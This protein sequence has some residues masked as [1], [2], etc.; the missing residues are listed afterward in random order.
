MKE[1]ANF[2]FGK[3]QKL[4]SRKTLEE[5]FKSESVYFSY[6]LKCI[7]LAKEVD[8]YTLPKVATIAPKRNFK[9]AVDRN[10]IKR[11]IRESYR[12]NSND[13]KS[14]F[15]PNNEVSLAFIYVGKSLEPYKVFEKSM[16][17]ILGKIKVI[18]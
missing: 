1:S 5:L 11:L 12:L 13:F 7:V 9:K 16:K 8:K 17:T 2:R 4:K 6:P 18:N 3:S 14:L 15:S 10:R